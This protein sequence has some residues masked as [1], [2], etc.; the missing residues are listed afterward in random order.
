MT[1][2]FFAPRHGRTPGHSAESQIEP[3]AQAC[4]GSSSAYGAWL[5]ELDDETACELRS[6]TRGHPHSAPLNF[7]PVAKTGPRRSHHV[8]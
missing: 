8:R 3:A 1:V 2:Q 4:S 5:R 7:R 6:H